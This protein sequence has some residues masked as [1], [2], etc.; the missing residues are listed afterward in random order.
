MPLQERQNLLTLAKQA[1]PAGSAQWHKFGNN[2]FDNLEQYGTEENFKGSQSSYS[3][4]G[5][6]AG[7]EG[8]TAEVGSAIQIP[9]AYDLKNSQTVQIKMNDF[10]K[11]GPYK[12]EVARPYIDSSGTNSLVGEIMNAGTPVKDSSLK[13]GWRW[14]VPGYFRG[15]DGI[16]ELV[17]DLD[18]NTIVHFN[19]V[20]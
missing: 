5:N 1:P 14:D 16:W 6:D 4:P 15:A 19:F 9:K 2:R 7:L 3:S 13:N 20:N 8:Q 10:V 18:T 11:K 12:G 17:V